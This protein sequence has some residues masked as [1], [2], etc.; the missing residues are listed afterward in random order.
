M[1]DTPSGFSDSDVQFKSLN[2][3][4]AHVFATSTHLCSIASTVIGS[5]QQRFIS[6]LVQVTIKQS[7]EL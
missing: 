5:L 1:S 6:K 3:L 4:A 7:A 2:K